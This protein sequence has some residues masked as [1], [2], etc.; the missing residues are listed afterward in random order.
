MTATLFVK[1]KLGDYSNWKRGYDESMLIR[2]ESIIA[3][4][5]VHHNV[6][7]QMVNIVSHQFKDANAMMAFANSEELRAAMVG[8]GVIGMPGIWFGEDLEFTDY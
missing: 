2:K 1:H 7:D 3:A 8:A 5:S 6:K 4:A